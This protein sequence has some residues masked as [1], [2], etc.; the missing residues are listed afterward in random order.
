MLAQ[1]LAGFIWT[2]NYNTGKKTTFYRVSL[3]GFIW[4]GNYNSKH[5]VYSPPR[6]LAGFIW[7]GNYNSQEDITKLKLLHNSFCAVLKK[8]VVQQKKGLRNSRKPLKFVARL[9]RFELLT[10]RFVA[11]CS[12][13]LSYSRLLTSM[14]ISKKLLLVK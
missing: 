8:Q 13:Q 6:S 11:C 5:I 3:A 10:Y 2:G 1:S 14:K 4:T 12:I 9:K 7:T